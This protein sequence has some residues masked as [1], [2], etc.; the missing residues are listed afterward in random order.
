L[1]VKRKSLLQRYR[2]RRDGQGRQIVITAEKSET[3]IIRQEPRGQVRAWCGACGE[4]IECLTVE[5]AVTLTGL[6]AREIFRLVEAEGIH[7]CET[8]AGHL[9]VCP[10]SVARFLSIQ[11]VTKLT[12]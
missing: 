5:Q 1:A 9:L 7:S 3:F 2:L 8:A 4:E 6:S 10:N 12:C 11:Q